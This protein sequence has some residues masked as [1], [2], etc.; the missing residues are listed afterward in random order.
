MHIEYWVIV[1]YNREVEVEADSKP[2]HKRW[3]GNFCWIL[4]FHSRCN[5]FQFNPIVI[6]S[7]LNAWRFFTFL[8][9]I[10]IENNWKCIQFPISLWLLHYNHRIIRF[11]SLLYRN[12]WN[13]NWSDS[14]WCY[15]IF[16]HN[17]NISAGLNIAPSTHIHNNK[18]IN[19]NSLHYSMIG[20]SFPI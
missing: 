19:M 17:I 5:G 4:P 9:S 14:I 7:G 1:P 15:L 8:V 3:E 11:I 2:T 10:W 13:G 12:G 16:N 18:W 6:Y 20:I